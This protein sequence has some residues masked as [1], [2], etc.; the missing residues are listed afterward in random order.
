ML[1]ALCYGSINPD[2]VHHLPALPRPGDDV[3]SLRSRITYG[4]GGA[5]PAVALAAWGTATAV[6]GNTLGDD[7][8]GRWLID[9]LAARGVDVSMV[10][11]DPDVR[12]P[13][14]VVL[15]GADGERTIISSGYQDVTWQS[16]DE[17]AWTGRSV[18]TIDAYSA[19]WGARAIVEA[20]S[21][22]VPTVGLDVTGAA[23]APL[24]VCVWS[25]HEHEMDDAL[26]LSRAGP[27]VVL[28]SGR[29]S[30]TWCREGGALLTVRP[31]TMHSIDP[32]GA[33]DTL[34]AMVA[35]GVAGRWEPH[36]IL[37]MAVAAASLTVERERGEPIPDLG[38]ITDLAGTLVD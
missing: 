36:R 13:H 37:P 14:C 27:D 5:N 32:T 20:S 22:G 33:G 11:L 3:R 4:G 24:T 8:L 30:A 21:A 34:A 2:L 35:Y 7:P 26:A 23:A 6:L 10:E 1:S 15:V 12:T 28:T 19:R 9:D 18:A 38:A 17:D 16:V 29:E 25:S 31:P